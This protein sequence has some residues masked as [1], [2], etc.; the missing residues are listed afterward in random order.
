[1]ALQATHIKFALDLQAKY[2]VKNLEKYISG[3]NYPDSRFLTGVGR[4]K[5]HD[6]DSL[7]LLDSDFK[8]GWHNHL[9]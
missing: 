8:K 6:L 1:M 7:E 5:T 2:N 9:I 4:E 3:A